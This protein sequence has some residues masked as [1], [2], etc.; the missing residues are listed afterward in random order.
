MREGVTMVDTKN[1]RVLFDDRP[2]RSRTCRICHGHGTV[3]ESYA[4][5][6]CERERLDECFDGVPA[7]VVCAAVVG[8]FDIFTA[9][10]EAVDVAK[11]A[12]RPVAFDFND[13][14][15]VVRSDDD[16]DKIARAWWQLA[17]NETPEATFARR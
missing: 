17:H 8:S 16:P 12:R 9:C 13:Q 5:A 15:V 14:L 11:R 3:I 1:D 7:D 4:L 10:K 2:V 6:P